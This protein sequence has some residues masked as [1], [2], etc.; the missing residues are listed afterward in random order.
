[1]DIA[2]ALS[3]LCR[4]TGHCKEFY[5]V[6]EH[7]VRVSFRC[8]EL[9]RQSERYLKAHDDLERAQIVLHASRWGLHHDDAEAYVADLNRPLKHQPE[10]ALYRDVEKK[11]MAAIANKF[12]LGEEPEEVALA[13]DE[14]LWTEV[15]DIMQPIHPD[16]AATAK[17]VREPLPHVRIAC[18]VP[19]KARKVFLRRFFELFPEF[20]PQGED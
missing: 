17:S 18:W 1:M 2:H 16:W 20:A 5:S 12:Q 15:R 11:V 14:L 6:A 8:E 19:N 4:Y 10:L 13:D 7:S 3:N 9:A